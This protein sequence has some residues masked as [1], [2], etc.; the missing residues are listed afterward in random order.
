[1]GQVLCKQAVYE[2]GIVKSVV[3]D[4]LDAMG[5]QKIPAGSRVLVKPNMLGPAPPDHAMLTH[6]MVVRAAVEYVLDRGARVLVADSQAMGSFEKVLKESGIRDALDGLDVECREF[7]NSVQMDVGEPFGKIEIAEDALNADVIINLPK[8]KTHSQML[9]TLAVK[10]LFGCV[11]GLR[12]PQ[13]HLRA[14]VD[15]ERFAALLVRI[16][17]T[18]K[19]AFNILD[20]VLA[21][22]GPGPGKGGIPR[23]VGVL[24]AGSDAFSLDSAVCRMLGIPPE[25]LFTHVVASRAGLVD[26]PQEILGELPLVRGFNFPEMKSMFFGPRQLHAFMRRHLIQRPVIDDR[27]CKACRDCADYCPAEAIAFEGKKA[28]FN[29]DKCIRCYCCL[30]VCPHGA[31]RAEEPPLG[32]LFNKVIRRK[33]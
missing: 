30:E 31:M 26:E 3:H 29:F 6:P 1:M 28:T 9:L 17:A 5:G 22:E 24:M 13:W 4:F 19:P 12:K 2:Y 14:G 27:G 8:L 23:H 15:R 16:C 33:E 20:G 7:K 32:R 25:Q 21:M 11:V 10:N 18:L